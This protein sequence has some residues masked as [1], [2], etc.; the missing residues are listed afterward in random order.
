MS[1]PE[2]RKIYIS[3]KSADSIDDYMK[4]LNSFVKSFPADI[5]AWQ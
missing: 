2:A 4:E 3:V 1:D 5:E